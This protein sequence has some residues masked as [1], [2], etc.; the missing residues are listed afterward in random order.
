M[1]RRLDEAEHLRGLH[2]G[3][4]AGEFAVGLV[5]NMEHV[6]LAAAGVEMFQQADDVGRGHVGQRLDQQRASA[7]EV[8][9][10]ASVLGRL[11]TRMR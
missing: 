10:V 7:S 11:G 3:D 8:A 9:A 6:L 2:Y 5:A 4:H 1:P